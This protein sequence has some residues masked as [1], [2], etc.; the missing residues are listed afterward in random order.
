M[1]HKRFIR[2]NNFLDRLLGRVKIIAPLDGTVVGLQIHTPGGVISPGEALLDI[3]P[4]GDRLV[5]EAKI[6]PTDID[7]VHPGLPAHV[8]LTP[9]NTRS[10]RPIEGR[11]ASVSADRLSDERTGESYYLARVE[12][13]GNPANAL[14]GASLYPGMPAEVMI[15]TGARTALDYFLKPIT[16][17]L[18]R[19]F[20]ED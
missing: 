1:N 8:R 17:S 3:V 7:V 11:I 9:F 12:L 16:R 6:D 5:I 10:T 13:K 20:R 14:D 2:F 15:V 4:S 18:N 19:A